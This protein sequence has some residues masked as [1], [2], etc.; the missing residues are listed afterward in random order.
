MTRQ[1]PGVGG[2][3]AAATCPRPCIKPVDSASL[4]SRFLLE[5]PDLALHITDADVDAPDLLEGYLGR[6]GDTLERTRDLRKI[7]TWAQGG[8][9]D[10]GACADISTAA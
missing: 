7:L 6:G 8:I 2:A 1:R 3:A 10:G 9:S 5:L 4:F